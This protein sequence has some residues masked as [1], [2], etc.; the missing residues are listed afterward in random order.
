MVLPSVFS[1]KGLFS[2][3]TLQSRIL[4]DFWNSSLLPSSSNCV[5]LENR[6]L[7]IR[8]VYFNL[9]YMNIWLFTK[10]IPSNLPSSPR[11]LA[12]FPVD[13]LLTASFIIQMCYFGET[14]VL[15]LLFDYH[16]ET[17]YCTWKPYCSYT[18]SF[19]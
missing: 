10:P 2:R 7:H 18:I 4:P 5:S 9:R 8:S 13:R 11:T 17:N 6:T 1:T 14:E 16:R 15:N 19:T 3:I 12:F